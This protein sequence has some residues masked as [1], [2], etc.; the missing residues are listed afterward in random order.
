MVGLVGEVAGGIG[1]DPDVPGERSSGVVVLDP[2]EV[3]SAGSA[4]GPVVH[5]DGGVV[6]LLPL[7]QVQ[8]GKLAARVGPREGRG[9][10]VAGDGSADF[11]RGG[12]VV[13]G[14][15]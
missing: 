5:R 13:G 15:A 11:Y 6:V 12:A 2:E 4:Q 10:G 3:L 7:W 1:V 9:D 8:A 14:V